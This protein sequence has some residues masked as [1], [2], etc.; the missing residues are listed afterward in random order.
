[1]TTQINEFIGQI[2]DEVRLSEFVI[3][4]GWDTNA[5]FYF[6]GTPIE[7]NKELSRFKKGSKK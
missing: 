4:K 6:F 7:I 5:P 2:I 1:M 3:S